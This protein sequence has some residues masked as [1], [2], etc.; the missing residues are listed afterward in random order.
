MLP[1]EIR[2]LT[3]TDAQAFSKL[4]LEAL[5][6]DPRAFGSSVEEH[7]AMPAETV[8]HRLTPQ[9]HSDFVV[10]AFA[11][12]TLVGVAGF[13]RDDR[14]KTRHKGFIW[15]V[16]VTADWR[17]KGVA[18]RLLST[19]LD[20]LRSYNDLDHVGLHVTSDQTAAR[21]LYLSL[22]FEIIGHE[23]RAFKIGDDY[24]DQDQMVL[25]L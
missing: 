25:W 15:G 4:R 14:A 3:S 8:A 12:Y 16:Y 22:G 18:R 1:V 11:N 9:P 23:R 2:I 19:I 17:G 7:L 5:E 10:G 20:R 21:R 24:I 6:G 13:H